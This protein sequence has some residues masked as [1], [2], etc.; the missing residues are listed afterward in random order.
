VPA[1]VKDYE[2]EEALRGGYDGLKVIQPL[3]DRVHAAV[4]PGGLI[5]IEIASSTVDAVL[6]LARSNPKLSGPRIEDDFE[7]LPR[8]L[9]AH[10]GE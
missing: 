8:V 2:P 10:R 1:N 5:L 4:R 9:V 3:L 7:G 6:E